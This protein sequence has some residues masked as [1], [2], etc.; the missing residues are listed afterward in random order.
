MWSSQLPYREL[1]EAL[2]DDDSVLAPW[3]LEHGAS[4]RAVLDWAQA[5]D[6]RWPAHDPE[7]CAVLYALSRVE[8]V[9]TYRGQSAWL[10]SLGL[11]PFSPA[12]FH[13]YF[14]EVVCVEEGVG[15]PVVV[16][17]QWPGWSY[18]NLLIARAGCLVRSGP[19]WMVPGVAENSTL[20]WGYVRRRPCQ[21]PSHGW[22]S[23]SQWATS[24]RRDYCVDGTF[25]YNVDARHQAVSEEEIELVRHRCYLTAEHSWDFPYDHGYTESSRGSS[26]AEG[27]SRK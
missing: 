24:F 6:G 25:G 4:V 15:P 22:G 1:L 23:N 2:P 16:G 11:Q 13:P 21:D 7:S 14:C 26:S 17:V 20:Y 3:A 5:R 27:P 19:E 8:Q 10:A 18:G 12:E 9:L